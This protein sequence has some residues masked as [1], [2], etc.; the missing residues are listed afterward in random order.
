MSAILNILNGC[1]ICF[2]AT[3]K[4]Y[5]CTKFHLLNTFQEMKDRSLKVHK[6][7]KNGN[8]IGFFQNMIYLL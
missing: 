7:R 5:M 8:H 3:Y 6:N 4:Y 2:E 1:N